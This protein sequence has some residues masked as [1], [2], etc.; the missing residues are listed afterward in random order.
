[1]AAPNRAVVWSLTYRTQFFTRL[2]PIP[3]R[4]PRAC[5]MLFDARILK[6][7]RHARDYP[8]TRKRTDA[9][10]HRQLLELPRRLPGDR[11]LLPPEGRPPRRGAARPAS[12]RLRRDL[13]DERQL[14]AAQ[15]AASRHYLRRLHRD[16]RTLRR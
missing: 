12:A 9:G 1:M 13:A 10:M 15:L 8:G 16:L 4:N 7:G 6:E 5:R 3:L 2:Q 14:Y 11:Y